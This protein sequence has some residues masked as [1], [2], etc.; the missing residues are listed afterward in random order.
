MTFK[1][2]LA[3]APFLT[4]EYDDI[5]SEI[6][7][8]RMKVHVFGNSPSPAVA[9]CGQQHCGMLDNLCPGDVALAKQTSIS[10][11]VLVS[12][13]RGYMF[14]HLPKAKNN[15]RQKKS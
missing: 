1:D 6:V 12:I 4:T 10:L 7:E 8:C 9:T 15:C 5:S 3:S 14:Q 2:G 11:R 13:V